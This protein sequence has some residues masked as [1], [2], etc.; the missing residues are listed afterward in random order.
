M[1]TFVFFLRA[2]QQVG[3]AVTAQ[4]CICW[5]R[6]STLAQLTR[7]VRENIGV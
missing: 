3:V 2:T 4:T 6:C 5:V 1:D 7:Y